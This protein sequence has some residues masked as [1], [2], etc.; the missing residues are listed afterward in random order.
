[1][2]TRPGNMKDAN[3]S[4]Y[5]KKQKKVDKGYDGTIGIY[6]ESGSGSLK[7]GKGKAK[8]YR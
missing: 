6:S 7:Y 1:M 3:D 5:C 2:E 8:Q 4:Q